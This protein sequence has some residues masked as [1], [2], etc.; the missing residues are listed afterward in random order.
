MRLLRT[1]GFSSLNLLKHQE[2]L[3]VVHAH[4]AGAGERLAGW[5][6]VNVWEWMKLLFLG[7]V[8]RVDRV[9]G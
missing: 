2:V 4:P 5:S 7:R 3:V 6:L 8:D 1:E 9:V